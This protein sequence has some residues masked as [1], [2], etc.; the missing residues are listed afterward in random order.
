MLAEILLNEQA[1]APD[2]PYFAVYV[3]RPTG[4]GQSI[5]A[6]LEMNRVGPVTAH[7]A[8][9][10]RPSGFDLFAPELMHEAKQRATEQGVMKI[11]LVRF[12]ILRPERRVESISSG[13][14]ETPTSDTSMPAVIRGLTW[15]AK[16]DRL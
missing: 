4:A 11:L 1:I 7:M 13:T 16:T 5:V 10:R 12:A 3:D 6:E 8:K 15:S 14:I 9:P 2:E